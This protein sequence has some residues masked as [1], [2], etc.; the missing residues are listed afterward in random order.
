M[1]TKEPPL[2]TVIDKLDDLREVKRKLGEQIK[3]AEKDYN[4]LMAKLQDRLLKEGMDKATG[5]KATVSISRVVVANVV[6][7]DAV[8]KFVKKTGNFQLFQRRISDPAFR[9]LAEAKGGVPG[10][11]PFTKVGLNLTSLK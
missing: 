4:D 7:W 10:L 1:A 6:D 9:E 3:V 2:G 11:E 8:Y 5:K